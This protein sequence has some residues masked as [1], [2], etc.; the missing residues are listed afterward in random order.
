M[1]R[2]DWK[3]YGYSNAYYYIAYTVGL[4]FL[5]AFYTLDYA[6]DIDKGELLYRDN[7]VASNE[8]GLFKII[9]HTWIGGKLYKI[10]STKREKE[11]VFGESQ[12]GNKI[13]IKNP[14]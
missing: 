12:D 3:Q 10:Y 14:K 5:V 8:A 9:N 2:F 7:I 4:I 6:V 13:K 11:I 1:N